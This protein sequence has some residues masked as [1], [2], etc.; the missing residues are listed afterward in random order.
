MP[1]TRYLVLTT[2]RGVVTVPLPAGA[3]LAIGRDASC[4]IVVPD[5]SVSRRHALLHAAPEPEIEDLESRNGTYVDGV[6]LVPKRRT[7]IA[8]QRVRLGS[9]FIEIETPDDVSHDPTRSE[10]RRGEPLVEAPNMRA[11]YEQLAA[12]ATSDLAVLV[13]GESGV[14]K[15]V[16]A[17]YVHSRSRRSARPFIALNCAALSES[18]LEAELFGFE[19]G[20]FTGAN[21]AKPGLLEVAHEGTVFLDEIAE[22]TPA[23]QAKLLRVLETGDTKRLGANI[24]K[25]VDVRIVAAT[26]ARLPAPG[27]RDDLYFRLAGFVAVVPPLRERRIEIL[28]LARAFAGRAAQSKRA[29]FGGFT[30]EAEAGLLAYAFPGN[31]RELRSIVERGLVLAG[32]GPVDVAHLGMTGEDG[33][34]VHA[35]S[36]RAQRGEYEKARILEALAQ[37][38]G[39]QSHAAKLLGMPRRTFVN[40]LDAYGIPRP[41]KKG[42]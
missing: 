37:T 5:A 30:A 23:I 40:K 38:D 4:E 19:K 36:F 31:V 17:Q 35:T 15:E 14:G 24:V 7:K 27:F 33:A 2:E 41:F 3:S 18:L 28:P 12:V 11:L 1:V 20:A 16:V 21:V 10:P 8:G 25:R 22:A 13:L 42:H 6:R 39:N 9:V 32:G 29:R 26:N 34:P